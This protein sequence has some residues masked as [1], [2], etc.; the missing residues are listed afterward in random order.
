MSERPEQPPEGRLIAV[1]Q[2]RSRLSIRKAAELAGMSD[3]RWRQIV[4]GYQIVSGG[5][6]IPVR[7][8][9]ETLARMAQAVGVTAEQLE[10]AGRED[11]AEE[12]RALSPPEEPERQLT[13]EEMV[14][15]FNDLKRQVDE[16][17]GIVS[18]LTERDDKRNSA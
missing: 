14:A 12:L 15:Q 17:A 6:R 2:K 11:A 16:I 5:L 3:A 7:G 8:P 9:A 18:Q 10:E 1:A 13:V 4:N